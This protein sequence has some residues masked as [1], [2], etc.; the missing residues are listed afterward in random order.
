MKFIIQI[1]GIVLRKKMKKNLMAVAGAGAAI[2]GGMA[3]TKKFKKKDDTEKVNAHTQDGDTKKVWVYEDHDLYNSAEAD[4]K[5]APDADKEEG[6]E[7]LTEL[8]A[9]Y[10]DQ[11][12]SIGT[13]STRREVEDVDKTKE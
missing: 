13:P 3:M 2:A 8:D 5:K 1:G 4:R 6:K 9:A 7:G 11:W 10:Y 12:Q